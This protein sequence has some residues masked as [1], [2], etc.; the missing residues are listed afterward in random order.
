MT[1]KT[2]A[3]DPAEL[4]TDEETARVF[5]EE[6]AREGDAMEIARV[7]G[8]VA[9]ALGM[10][11]LARS[12]GMTAAELFDLINPYDDEYDEVTLRDLVLRLAAKLPPT[13]ASAAE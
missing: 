13:T 5:L 9:R 6:T 2:K 8:Q 11:H 1:L 10:I 3:W 12:V 4:I 7:T